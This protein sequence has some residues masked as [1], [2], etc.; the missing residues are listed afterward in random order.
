MDEQL[1]FSS[2]SNAIQNI[3]NS[4]TTLSNR[5]SNVAS[6]LIPEINLPVYLQNYTFSSDGVL[7][8]YYTTVAGI[9]TN[10]SKQRTWNLA[11]AGTI[12][13]APA[14][15][16]F[17][18][19]FTG[20]NTS[21]R[22]FID[23]TIAGTF[24]ID[25]QV[26]D[27]GTYFLAPKYKSKKLIL[28]VDLSKISLTTSGGDFSY[29]IFIADVDSSV[30]DS[31]CDG[32]SGCPN[33]QTNEVCYKSFGITYYNVCGVSYDNKPCCRCEYDNTPAGQI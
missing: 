29:N 24:T 3:Q 25:G 6:S 2:F 9:S 28:T 15:I 7:T 16:I 31:P 14:Y 12:S 13:S 26:Y 23:G 17:T 33:C 19:D 32:R 27:A 5:I 22:V 20:V 11:T 18:Y 1:I 4:L 21:Y 10:Q 30:F 8:P